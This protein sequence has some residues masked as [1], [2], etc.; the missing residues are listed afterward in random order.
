V[1]SQGPA[2][3]FCLIRLPAAIFGASLASKSLWDEASLSMARA[4]ATRTLA[5]ASTK[6]KEHFAWGAGGYFA[7]MLK[8]RNRGDWRLDRSLFAF[9]RVRWGGQT[10]AGPGGLGQDSRRPEFPR[11]SRSGSSRAFHR[12]AF[13]LRPLIERRFL[14]VSAWEAAIAR[15]HVARPQS[16]LP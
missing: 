13:A 7:V 10:L 16:K 4:L 14:A 12:R 2:R 8:R 3:I 6:P 11:R 5:A 1:E 9:Q 15:P